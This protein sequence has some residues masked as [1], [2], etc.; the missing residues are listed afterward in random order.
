MHFAFENYTVSL[1][2]LLIIIIIIKIMYTIMWS[3]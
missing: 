3:M 2:H 1:P